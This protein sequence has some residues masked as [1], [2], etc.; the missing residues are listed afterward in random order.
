MKT[1]SEPKKI[2]S[3]CSLSRFRLAAV[4]LLVVAAVALAAKSMM[5]PKLPWAVPTITVG[6]YPGGTVV[7]QA[8]NTIYVANQNDTTVSVIDGSKC[9]ADQKEGCLTIATITIGSD[10]VNDPQFPIQLVLDTT[11]KTI[12]ATLAGDND[13]GVAVINAA[14]CNA[15]QTGS[16]NQSPP[17]VTFPGT[18]QCIGDV[19][20]GCAP[21]LP[22]LDP[23]THTLY[24]ADANDGPIYILDTTTCNGASCNSPSVMQAPNLTGDSFAIDR[25]NR[26]IYL[27]SGNNAS[28]ALVFDGTHCNSIDHSN[29]SATT[30]FGV[31]PFPVGP[32]LI[33]PST[34]TYYLPTSAFN[35][36]LDPVLVIDTSTC[37]AT[38]STGCNNQATVQVGSLPEGVIL[39]SATKTVYV[40]NEE[41]NSISMFNGATCNATNH[42]GCSQPVEAIATGFNP[43]FYDFNPKT[44]TLY[45]P[46]QNTN[47]V[48]VLD[49]SKCNAIHTDGCTKFAPTTTVGSGAEHVAL[50]PNTKTLYVTNQDDNTVSVID[51]TVCNQHHLAGCNQTWPTIPVMNTPRFIGIN[52]V[53]NTIYVSN[54]GDGTLSIINGATCNRSA[55]SSCSQTQPTTAI[56]SG[57]QQIAVDQATNTIYVVN[58]GDG[59]VSVVSGVHCNATDMNGCGTTWA[60]ISVNDPLA[61]AFN[62]N[63]HTLYVA[64]GDDNTVSVISTLHCNSIESSGCSA[65]ATF[66]VGAVPRSIGIALEKNTVFIGNSVDLTVSVIDGSTCNGSS[67]SGCPQVPPPAIIVGAF[68]DAGGNGKYLLGRSIVFDEKKHIAYIPVQGDSDVAMLDTNACRAAHV[69]DCHVKIVNERMGGFSVTATV[70]ESTDTVYVANDTDGTISL[71]PIHH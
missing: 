14:T 26:N 56:G 66:P 65:V 51:A 29:C 44:H 39:D 52:S 58:T 27:T 59:T 61:L 23:T 37:N 25:S 20:T 36:T 18:T 22:I 54:L 62:P 47:E 8:T 53:T 71:F 63:N 46:S 30:N 13:D 5:P 4:G 42:S 16:C 21:A 64:D 57:P 17:I 67:I 60:T 70:D 55:V 41:S 6:N 7:D 1:K 33:D 49:A 34:H 3:L 35:D 2:H 45:A 50:N 32:A 19:P 9:N 11:T 43:V 48:W 68:P 12:Y 28:S 10:P 31:N 38:I 15:K 69:N 24:V 40:L